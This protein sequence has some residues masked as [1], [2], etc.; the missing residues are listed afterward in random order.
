MKVETNDGDADTY[1]TIANANANANNDDHDI[2][3]KPYGEKVHVVGG[4][5]LGSFMDIVKPKSTCKK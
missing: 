3:G 4:K 2:E 1:E 5:S